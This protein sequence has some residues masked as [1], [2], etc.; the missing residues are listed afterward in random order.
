MTTTD[1]LIEALATGLEP[2]DRGAVLRRIGVGAAAGLAVSGALMLTLLGARPDIQAALTSQVYWLK[3]AYALVLAGCGVWAVA[4]L[5]RP[6]GGGLAAGAVAAAMTVSLLAGIASSELLT[7]P[8]DMRAALVFGRSAVVC[9]WLIFLLAAPIVVGL[10]WA[11]RGLAPT[12]LRR[13]GFAAGA[14]GGAAG[15]W[16]Y[17]FHCPESGTPFIALWYTAGIALPALAGLILGPRLLRW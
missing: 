5:S 10:I 17:A 14:M 6:A 7:A 13:A 1:E 15:A 16:V 9:P 11:M 4:R 2:V 12:Q 8:E 3:S